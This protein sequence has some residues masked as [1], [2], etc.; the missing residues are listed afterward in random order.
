MD[1]E[2]DNKSI[3]TITYTRS[4]GLTVNCLLTWTNHIDF[5]A[6]KLSSTCY[7]IQNVKPFLSISALK[8]IY[9]SIFHSIM[10]YDIILW[11]NL[12]QSPVIFK[13]QKRVIR[14]IMGT[15]YR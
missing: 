15:A 12:P 10:S 9:H 1:I 14:V 3:S 7:L 11:G 2:Y 13:I 4:L 5:L 8:M 6:K